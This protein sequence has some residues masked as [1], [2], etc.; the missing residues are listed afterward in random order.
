MAGATDSGG[1]TSRLLVVTGRRGRY[2]TKMKNFPIAEFTWLF[3]TAVVMYYAKGPVLVG[4]A[5]V[6]FILGWLWLCKKFP[7]TAWFVFG[8][9]RAYL[10]GGDLSFNGLRLC[11]PDSSFIDLVMKIFCASAGIAAPIWSK[12]FIGNISPST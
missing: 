7:T 4:A 9:F 5:I 6:L 10:A 11:W 2:I 8:Q 3:V 12:D 1:R